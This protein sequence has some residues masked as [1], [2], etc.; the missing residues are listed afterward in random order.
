MHILDYGCIRHRI[1][2]Y[3]HHRSIHEFVIASFTIHRTFTTSCFHYLTGCIVVSILLYKLL[4]FSTPGNTSDLSYEYDEI[5]VSPEQLISRQRPDLRTV[6]WPD[7]LFQR[8]GRRPI[9]ATR[10]RIFERQFP[11]NLHLPFSSCFICTS[12]E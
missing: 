5:E 8:A 9:D 7:A 4:V 6:A 12:L 3:C 10:S 1:F 2:A 11:L